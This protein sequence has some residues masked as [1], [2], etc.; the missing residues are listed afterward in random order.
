MKSPALPIK[1]ISFKGKKGVETKGIKTSM[2]VLNEED[3]IEICKLSAAFKT[4]NEIVTYL[5]NERGKH[6]SQQ[7]ISLLINSPK[8]SPVIDRMQI[9]Y[10]QGIM[11][12]PI[13][14]KRNRLERL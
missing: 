10:S 1:Y 4:Q 3:K 5:E 6:V 8:W 2:D 14:H 13:A 12:V 11:K 7:S 9:Q